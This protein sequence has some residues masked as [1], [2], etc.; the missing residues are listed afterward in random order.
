VSALANDANPTLSHYLHEFWGP[1]KGYPAGSVS[2]IAQTSDGYLWIGTDKGLVRFDGFNFRRF[3]PASPGPFEIGA[4]RAV[5]A[6]AQGN[7]WTLLQNTR[8]FRYRR[9]AFELIRGQAEDGITA[10][11]L[12]TSGD[13]LLSSV[14]LGPLAYDGR[15][16][17]TILRTARWPEPGDVA[18][19]QVPDDR[20]ARF[21]WSYGNMPD[22]L[23]AGTSAVISIAATADGKIWLGTQ[24]KG[25]LYL[26]EGRV[27]APAKELLNAKTNCLSPQN[28]EL[29]IGT[30]KGVWHWNGNE[31]TRAG[32]PSSLLNVEVLSMV[33]DRD[34]N[35]WVGTN[36][37]LFQLKGAESS[38]SATAIPTSGGPV[39]ALFED[40]EGNLWV[41]GERGIERF[42]SGAFYTYTEAGSRSESGGP[43]YVDPEGRTWFAPVSGGLHWLRGERHGSVTGQGLERD[44]AYSIAGSG[45][46]LWIGWQRS[47]LTRLQYNHGTTNLQR[48]TEA[49][50]LPQNS[51]YSVYQGHDG[52]VWVGT[53]SAGASKFDGRRFTTYTIE[54]GLGSNSVTSILETRDGTVWFGTSGGLSS[55]S[56]GQWRNLTAAGGLPS[57][58]VNCLFEDTSGTLWIGTSAGLAFL[59]S[60]H[61]QP[62]RDSSAL[63]RGQILGI[64]EDRFGWFWI[65]TDNHI[66]RVRRE[67]I[68]AGT[69][70][71]ADLYEYGT[72]DGLLSTEG[73]R[74]SKSVISDASGNIWF[75]TS[76]GLSV[77]NSSRVTNA[78]APAVAQI[79]GLSADGS[80]VN[81]Q[82]GVHIPASAKR[83]TLTYTG[84][85]LANPARVRFRYFLE[86]FD[87][88]W[89]DPVSTREAVYTNLHARS[90]RFRVLAS[91]SDGLWNGSGT[92]L[93]FVIEPFF[94]QTWWFRTTLL[95]LIL[96]L[97]WGAYRYRL[98]QLTQQFSLRLEERVGE[99]TR[100]ARE[101]HDTLLQS[102]Q[103]LLLRFQTASNLLPARPQEAKEKLD[104]SIDLAAQAI[105][106]GRD[107]VQ[108]LRLSA[109]ESNDLATALIALGK[110]LAA[111]KTGPS[112]C[113]FNVEVEGVPR[114]L[115][116][117]LRD[118]VYRIAGEALRNAF[119]HAQAQRIELEVHY[120]Q[121]DLRVRIRDDGRGM[122]SQIL[123]DKGR[124][125]H[126]GLHGMYER[127]K[128]AGG[129]LEVWS[130]LDSGTE[131]QLTL[132]ASTAYVA[133]GKR[134]I[135][136]FRKDDQR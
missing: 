67:K 94:W 27:Y 113:I 99:R 83:I 101:L 31:L 17:L 107:A 81:L 51:V 48:Y 55:L 37:G 49:D 126:W 33:R 44:V 1:E 79:E 4:V 68:S 14:G 108:G 112:S 127:A 56:N 115:H 10:M 111:E 23:A 136:G 3:E 43:V 13:V 25:L 73:V 77:V 130:E 131:I 121:Q 98:Y 45:D 91:N 32:V 122:D 39:T 15:Q 86:G 61:L 82:D 135:R 132:P 102:F 5:L 11:T 69:L 89:S 90:Y 117:I 9:G 71:P 80:P 84:L 103:A 72:E 110:E 74:R 76:R 60:G 18:Q 125:G 19:T 42:R 118:E 66:L 12:G 109:V 75:S 123:A 38:L 93:E 21:S 36:R 124:T 105:A 30:N 133:S 88:A 120:D 134:W 47:G 95:A 52:A 96:L 64:A 65:A 92:A 128:L 70:E 46:E 41:G 59:G 87:R 78:S 97:V 16:F 50:G 35:L 2:S 85:S 24:D 63:L 57:E 104:S 34:A 8:L 20:S 53:L 106:E 58:N 54:N 29:W 40:R 100:I 6:D 62:P 26:L 114:D 119:R 28:S 7:L 129:N 116:P 22:R